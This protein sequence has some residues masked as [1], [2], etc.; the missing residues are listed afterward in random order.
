MKTNY[1]KLQLL[2]SFGIVNPDDFFD[3]SFGK[4]AIVLHG[5]YSPE[6]A[7][8]YNHMHGMNSRL[9]EYNGYVEF[10]KGNLTIFLS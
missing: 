7:M 9:N 5:K 2:I 4:S 8:K 6:I 3:V 1:R 10:T